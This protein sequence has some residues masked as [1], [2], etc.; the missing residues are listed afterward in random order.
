MHTTNYYK[1]YTFYMGKGC[2]LKKSE[3][4]GERGG[5]P[6]SPPLWIR[7][8]NVYYGVLYNSRAGLPIGLGFVLGLDLVY[9]WL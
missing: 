1:L 8:L 6:Q 4:I 2:L 9:G 7:H 5:R 3:P